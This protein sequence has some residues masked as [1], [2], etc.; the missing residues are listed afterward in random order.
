V[1][2]IEYS[3]APGGVVLDPFAGSGSTLRAAVDCGRRAIGIEI[4]E[5]YCA[6][7]VDR[8]RQQGLFQARDDGGGE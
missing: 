4:R 2:I 6:I 1:P 8:L 5:D 7:A 3:C